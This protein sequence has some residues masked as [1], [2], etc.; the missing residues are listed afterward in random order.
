MNSVPNSDSEQCTES[1]LSRVH[2]APNLGLACVRTAPCRRPGLA[3]SQAWPGRV[4]AHA[5][6]CH[7][8]RSTVSS[9]VPRA[10]SPRPSLAAARRVAGPLDHLAAL[11]RAVS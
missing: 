11:L 10:V 5:Q 9:D 1:K 6:S 2:S 8:A 7:S 3:V 4:A